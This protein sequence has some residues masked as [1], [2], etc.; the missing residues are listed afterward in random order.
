MTLRVPSIRRDPFCRCFLAA[1]ACALLLAPTVARAQTIRNSGLN[2]AQVDLGFQGNVRNSVIL[3]VIGTASTV[4]TG[5]PPTAMPAHAQGRVD[6]GSFTTMVPMPA[7]GTGYRVALPSPGA[8]VVA[9]LDAMITYNGA[10]T[11]SITVGRLNPV[12]G[13]TDVPAADL[14]VASP[15]IAPWTAGTQGA[16]IPLSGMPGLNI[17]TAAGD[18]TCQ[19][20]VPYTHNLA[21][22]LPDTR[23]A[24]A[25][26]TVVVYT[27]AMP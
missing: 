5:D 11:A 23:P 1:A 26:S 16:Q 25:F 18:L 8:I 21:I 10:T 27:G 15:A 13:V 6:F 14:R 3:T 24:G 20:G 22:F 2:D 7:T 9:T 17:C 4:L 12:G 19:N